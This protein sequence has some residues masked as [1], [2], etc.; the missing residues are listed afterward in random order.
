VHY[1][2]LA[3][4][5]ALGLALAA[6]AARAQTAY[7]T[8]NPDGGNTAEDGLRIEVYADATIQIYREGAEQL[9]TNNGLSLAIGSTAYTPVDWEGYNDSTPLTPVSQTA[10]TGEGTSVSPWKVVTVVQA[11][12]GYQTTF[13]ISYVLGDA[14]MRL[15]FQV[16]PP[17]DN[18][19]SLKLYWYA[20]SYLSGGDNGAAFWMPESA[21]PDA[22]PTVVGVTK[23][24]DGV[25]Q[26]EVMV[27]GNRTWDYYYSDYYGTPYDTI[28]AADDFANELNTNVETDNGIGAEWLLGAA[29]TTQDIQFLLSFS[30]VNELPTCGDGAVT[31][32]ETCDD[33]GTAGGDGCSALCQVEDGFNCTGAPSVCTLIVTC[34][35]GVIAGDEV[36]DD[37]GTAD[38]D[39]C[40]ALCQVEDGYTCT[41]T[42]S[43]CAHDSS[44]G[45][46]CGC[47]S[48]GGASGLTAGLF[49]A[50][51]APRLRRRRQ[52]G[53]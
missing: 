26:Y 2:S 18:A 17:A 48:G 12:E 33:G 53:A 47:G 31:G 35:D 10:V 42:P 19:A 36:C 28:A 9:Y 13:T 8:I 43:V 14:Y 7:V 45:G 39:G 6:P 34:G 29:T 11:A 4:A 22:V 25:T 23:E 38:G 3:L 44:G 52:A 16:T 41:G 51:L 1:R 40:S 37:G 50:F 15:R 24:V 46:G 20:D 21:P 30:A 27:V 32:F 49:L 5:A